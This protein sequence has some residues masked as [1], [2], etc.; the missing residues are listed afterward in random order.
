MHLPSVHANSDPNPQ[1]ASGGTRLLFPSAPSLCSRRKLCTDVENPGVG[2]ETAD[3]SDTQNHPC[4]KGLT[5]IVQIVALKLRIRLAMKSCTNDKSALP[6]LPAPAPSLADY[7]SAALIIPRLHEE[8]MHGIMNQ[9]CQVLQQTDGL[10][11]EVL[12]DSLQ[13]LNRELLTG[14]ALDFGACFPSVQVRGLQRPRFALGRTAE[15]LAWR[16]KFYPPIEFVFLLVGPDPST[17][18]SQ[19]LAATL[20]WLGRDRLHLNEL[21]AA[22]SAEEMQATLAR[23]HLVGEE[24]IDQSQ[25]RLWDGTNC[26]TTTYPGRVRLSRRSIG[27]WRRAR[28]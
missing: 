17:K 8:T 27:P 14:R 22:H 28:L 12:S 25:T 20:S 13:A 10:M 21:G 15:P 2:T 16:A 9:L 19:R 7:T 26:Q 23:F 18:E 4:F 24:Q 11:Q 1:P 5:C 6:T 3:R